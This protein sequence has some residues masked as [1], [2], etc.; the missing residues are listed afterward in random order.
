MK[1]QFHIALALVFFMIVSCK[2]IP[3]DDS[4][5]EG[6]LKEGP[7]FKIVLNPETGS[8]YRYN[9]SNNTETTVEY[10]DKNINS[11]NDSKLGIIYT[12]GRDSIGDIV[13]KMHFEKIVSKVKN[14]N[15]E[16]EYDADNSSFS[17][18]PME[19]M[20]GVLKASSLDVHLKSNGTLKSI[21]GY[22]QLT[23]TLFS[24]LQFPDQNSEMLAREQWN[25]TIESTM[26]KQNISQFFKIFPDSTVHLREKWRIT[27]KHEGEFGLLTTTTFFVKAINE[28]RVFIESYSEIVSDNTGNLMKN[29]IQKT[30][31][32]GEQTGEYVMEKNSGMLL[33]SEMK[34]K[35]KGTVS[36]NNTEVPIQMVSNIR[37]T[38]NKL[39]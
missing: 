33:S 24:K 10:G 34:M 35:I 1:I 31:L 28:D 7:A 38:G 32:K 17:V 39:N 14:D 27:N 13:L 15:T 20:L 36:T 26:I 23:E 4:K 18:N 29:V 5:H 3:S 25:K 8:K 21:E 9:I 11:V 6:Y 19:K 37:M 30:D 12:A 16:N 22:K 2:F